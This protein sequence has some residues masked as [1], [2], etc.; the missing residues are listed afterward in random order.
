M[1][2]AFVVGAVLA[3]L[4][5]AAAPA[6]EVFFKSPGPGMH[7][8]AGLPIRVWGDLLPRDEQP[9]FPRAELYWDGTLADTAINV[10]SAFNYFPLS[11]PGELTLPGGHELKLR[12]TF[13]NSVVREVSM[14]VEV[15]PWPADRVNPCSAPSG[16][17]F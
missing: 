8:T 3:C 9:G 12:A 10:P 7:F 6:Q 5:P 11:V 15:D 16:Q 13:R 14:P 2:R 1:R 4:V 17:Q